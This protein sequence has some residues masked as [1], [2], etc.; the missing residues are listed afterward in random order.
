[1]RLSF[2]L[3]AR[4]IQTQKL[5]PRM[6]QSMEI[7]QLPILALQERIEQ[8]L[9]E[10]PLLE[11]ADQDVESANANEERDVPDAPTEGERE[12]VIDAP[13]DG[14]EDFERLLD[15][16]REVPD[17]FDDGP[18]RSYS[19]I[20]DASTRHQDTIANIETRP[21]TL[22]DH[23]LSQLREL[24]LTPFVRMMAERIISSLD[25]RDG[26][27]L[28]V[29]LY[30]LL[31]PDAVTTDRALADEAL[32]VVQRL[33]PT[34][35]AARNLRE[36]LL[37]QLR[38]NTPYYQ[39]VHRLISHHLEDL[40]DNRLPAIEKATKYNLETIKLAWAEL[41]KLNP[42]PGGTYADAHVPTILPD[43]FVEKSENGTYQVILEDQR[44][45]TLYISEYYRQRLMSGQ[46]TTEEKEYIKRKIN[47][48]QWLI[49]AIEQRRN[50]LM[51]VTQAI[52]DYQT[53]FLD[54][55]PEFIQPLKMQQIADQVKV[56]L[57]T[58][59]RAVDDKWI[60]TPRGIMPLRRFFVGGTQSE[61]GED[62]AWD[63]IRIKLQEIVDQEDKTDPL[64][65]DQLVKEFT[66]QGLTVARRT[67]TK[68]RQKMNIPS[69][70][71]RRDWSATQRRRA[72]ENQP[73]PSD[74]PIRRLKVEYLPPTDDVAEDDHV[75]D[76]DEVPAPD[77]VITS[78]DVIAGDA[79]IAG[80][81]DPSSDDVL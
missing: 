72:E 24:E 31:P 20:E 7:L 63:I 58:V 38:P 33:D 67:I 73:F 54:D 48:A 43:V 6:I 52:V 18:S 65:D 3:D 66:R 81:D 8:E 57:T 13:Q 2:G 4:Q 41:R 59:S 23:L 64:S 61:E 75:T 32:E 77:D 21:E 22:N 30:D 69:S 12:L 14:V 34:G 17:Y 80:D 25:A 50:T 70:R 49:E 44:T 9:S 29:P 10:N 35:V 79:F 51:R 45:P 62:V 11:I 42:K 36:C 1:M 16:D 56:H 19:Q 74:E 39:Q 76:D 28:R 27:Y 71:Q 78:H 60:Q 68:Y 40:R 47:A 55:G 26:G 5:A 53:R 46:A 37:L 15:L